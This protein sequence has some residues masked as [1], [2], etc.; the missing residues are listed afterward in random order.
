MDDLAK[1]LAI[2]KKTLYTQFRSKAALLEAVIADKFASVSAALDRVT[3]ERGQ[4]FVAKLHQLLATTQRELDEIKP[5]FVR[6]MRQRAPQVFKTVEHRRG[7]LIQRH[8]GRLFAEGQRAGKVR[9][10]VPAKIIIEILLGAVQAVM[11]PSKVEELGLTPKRG[12]VAI[13]KVVLEGALK[14]K[15]GKS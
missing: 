2:S 7:E 10:D 5:S 13:T 9:T 3:R 14:R 4:D 1:E 15:G 6:D 12:F 8:F 11:N